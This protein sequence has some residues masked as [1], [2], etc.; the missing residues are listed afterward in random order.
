M[1]WSIMQQKKEE[2][3]VHLWNCIFLLISSSKQNSKL[4]YIL[5]LISMCCQCKTMCTFGEWLKLSGMVSWLT[6]K[7]IFG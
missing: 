4:S 2:K 1:R 5:S 7:M 6:F 3:L